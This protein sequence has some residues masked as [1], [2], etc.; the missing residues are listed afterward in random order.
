MF[1]GHGQPE[2]DF[3]DYVKP[4]L[5]PHEEAA[6][7]QLAGFDGSVLLPLPKNEF[8]R[9]IKFYAD[10]AGEDEAGL[11][12]CKWGDLLGVQ[13]NDILKTGRT[14][15]RLEYAD[16][17]V[18]DYPWVFYTHS[19]YTSGYTYDGR[20]IGHNMGTAS[21]DLF[22]QVSHY[23][24]SDII[25]DVAYDRRMHLLSDTTHAMT[26]IYELGVTYFPSQN[27]QIT[28]GYRFEQRDDREGGDNHIVEVGLTRKF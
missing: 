21:R 20:V 1:G 14:D 23:L 8:L 15:F 3:F 27:W 10:A 17:I 19:Y 5:A 11:F 26:N 28:G 2:L 12:P 9:S 22:M 13:F 6:N 24:T 18:P 25:I 16:D 4:F 7:N